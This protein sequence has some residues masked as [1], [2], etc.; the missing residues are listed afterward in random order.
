[1]ESKCVTFDI[2]WDELNKMAI[3]QKEMYDEIYEI[4]KALQSRVTD[5][6]A[7]GV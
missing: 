4:I 7:A 6:E 3:N 1:M 2:F 5:L